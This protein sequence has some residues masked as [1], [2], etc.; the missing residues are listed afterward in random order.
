MPNI[1]ITGGAGFLGRH[2]CSKLLFEKSTRIYCIDNLVSGQRSN[3]E[4]F[5]KNE[6]FRFIEYDVNNSLIELQSIC[7]IPKQI[8]EIY[9]LACI[10]SPPIYKKYSIQTL[11]TNYIGTSNVLKLALKTGAKVLFTS[12]SEVYGDPNIHPQPEGYYGNV[13]TMGERSCYDEGKRIGET[14]M[15]EYRKK[16][17]VDTKVVR[18]FNTYGPYMDINDGRVITNFI[19]KA[20]KNEPFEIYGD[21][22][23]GRSFC[24]VTDM[25]SGL[26]SM[27][28]SNETGPINIGN[29]YNEFTLNELVTL[30]GEILNKPMT[31]VYKD[32][33]ENDPRQRRPDIS[34]AENKLNWTPYVSLKYG[35]IDTM[36]HFGLDV[37]E[38]KLL[39]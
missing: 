6:R 25:I 28:K 8:D 12:T 34:K 23:Q 10:A 38:K 11:D 17:G 21:G 39:P 24:Y 13:N 4:S 7:Q 18:I 30:Y 3:I 15:Y 31:V 14:L 19:Q 9:H 26:V 2:L 36:K 1:V 20:L 27:M 35:L 29:P 5:S 16:F 33:T 32:R 37:D 22:T